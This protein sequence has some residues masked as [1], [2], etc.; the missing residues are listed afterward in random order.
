[1]C[2]KLTMFRLRSSSR[3][4]FGVYKLEVSKH[5]KYFCDN[6]N[7]FKTIH[8]KPYL[9]AT[10]DEPQEGYSVL[11]K[12]SEDVRQLLEN[13][14]SFQDQ[15]P[16]T[17]EQVWSTAPYPKGGIPRTQASYA[18]RPNID[19]KETSILLFPGQGTQY[20]GMGKENLK[21]PIVQDMFDH[22]NELLGY[23]LLKL[24]LQGPKEE[25]DKTVHSQVAILVC[26]LAAIERLKDDTPS[27]VENCI[28]AAGFSVGEISALTF[29]GVMSFE[30]GIHV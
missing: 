19:P 18:L 13:A 24:C 20:V 17:E 3:L 9:Y 1:M 29:A 11:K 14:A 16:Q 21:V 28:A 15:L 25:L 12:P 8:T 4:F 23:D 30:R 27:A 10:K 22:A 5:L 7:F 26:S 2:S 6:S